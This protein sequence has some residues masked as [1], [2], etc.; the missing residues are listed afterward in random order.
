MAPYG[1]ADVVPHDGSWT[2]LDSMKVLGHIIQS[3][4]VVDADYDATIK[5]LCSSFYANAGLPGNHRLP[6]R[7]KLQL[8][9]RATLPYVDGHAVRWPYTT[10]RARQLDQVQRRMLTGLAQIKVGVSVSAE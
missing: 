5:L 3:T 1:S 9:Q 4:G 10:K 6:V 7:L 8:L 2:V